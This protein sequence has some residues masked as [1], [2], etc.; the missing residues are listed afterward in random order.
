MG[1]L[2]KD[3][4]FTERKGAPRIWDQYLDG[5]VWEV[6]YRKEGKNASIESLRTSLNAA[7]R[8]LGLSLRTQKLDENTLA[9]QAY[10]RERRT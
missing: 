2:L 7:A 6:D 9:I 1:K 5:Q 4:E 10:Q 3:F 8:S